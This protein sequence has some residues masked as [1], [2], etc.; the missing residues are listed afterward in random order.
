MF[1][2]KTQA[3]EWVREQIRF[4]NPILFENKVVRD[5]MFL[6]AEQF[7][8][9]ILR[10]WWA[11]VYKNIDVRPRMLTFK[12]NDAVEAVKHLR[13]AYEDFQEQLI[14]E[15][16][17]N[18]RRMEDAVILSDCAITSFQPS[19]AQEIGFDFLIPLIAID[20]MLK[21]ANAGKTFE[22]IE[23]ELN[24]G[25]F[26]SEF[27]WE[28]QE[29]M[30]EYSDSDIAKVL[31]KTAN[32]LHLADVLNKRLTAEGLEKL[33]CPVF[34]YRQKQNKKDKIFFRIQGNE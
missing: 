7:A 16:E 18:E 21:R 11:D 2:T 8:Y 29:T 9:I 5:E 30:W 26:G 31:W 32:E 4:L 33:G 25:L 19:K 34:I 10:S 27:I 15:E 22:E 12:G 1:D 17:F 24:E 20:L 14:D 23:I 3:G 28:L 6:S 13:E